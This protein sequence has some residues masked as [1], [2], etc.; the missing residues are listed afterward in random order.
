M[1]NRF[2]PQYIDFGRSA[3]SHLINENTRGIYE[4]IK[5]LYEKVDNLEKTVHLNSLVTGIE[6][7]SLRENSSLDISI[8]SIEPGGTAEIN[9][10]FHYVSVPLQYPAVSRILHVHP[11]TK[12][13]YVD[14]RCITVS[15]KALPHDV[16]TNPTHGLLS[17]PGN[18]YTRLREITT[19]DTLELEYN[20]DL[21]N[22]FVT[23]HRVNRIT[24]H[25][26]P[27]GASVQAIYNKTRDDLPLPSIVSS[28]CQINISPRDIYDLSLKMSSRKSFSFNKGLI[29]ALGVRFL[30]IEYVYFQPGDFSF[31]FDVKF[32]ET[33]D[34]PFLVQDMH[35]DLI[36]QSEVDSS[37]VPLVF[38]DQVRLFNGAVELGSVSFPYQMSEGDS[39]KVDCTI[40]ASP[41]LELAP[42]IKGLRFDL[43]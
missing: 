12:E 31:T 21:M 23:N 2:D 14:D 3:S 43:G 24:L 30:G 39:L 8:D 20:V 38:V 5:Y 13:F 7:M 27:Y 15:P 11:V 9:H 18:F 16:E 40:K 41:K 4:N 35:V 42:Q 32:D 28:P 26:F 34:H 29:Q 17:N 25:A 33:L 1:T 6:Q 36:N 19:S 37:D 10:L 22:H